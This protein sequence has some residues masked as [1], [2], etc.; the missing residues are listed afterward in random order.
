MFWNKKK[1]KRLELELRAPKRRKSFFEKKEEKASNPIFSKIIFRFVFLVFIASLSYIIFFSPFLEI[2]KVYLEGVVELKYDDVYQKI[3]G[4][5]NEKY[6]RIIPK[7]SFIILP[8]EK[9]KSELQNNFKKISA[10][11]VEKI[12][13]DKI[14]VKIVE[15]KALLIWCSAGPCYII[16]ENGYA[17]IGV[18]FESDEI[19]QNNLLSVVD[20]SGRSI[21][22][23]EKILN[24]GYMEFLISIKD[25]F[26]KE[27]DIKI[28]NEY[29]TGSRMAEEA[30]VMTE[31][32]W[33]I[34][35][36][37]GLPLEDSI[38]TLKT[39]LEKETDQDNRSK[40]DYVDLRAKNRVYYKFKDESQENTE[41]KK[42]VTENQQ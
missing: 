27:T 5:L 35:F 32:G 30:W 11:E 13:P 8:S 28:T 17:Y 31:E 10:V 23:K 1:N 12:F 38:T 3:E 41:E 37:S 19:K 42:N 7:D 21:D 40:L 34:L 24:I 18:D 20:N 15:R 9:I 2:K 16:D 14:R 4:L 29:Q 36:S 33:R 39:F 22:M 26:E 25:D 6:F